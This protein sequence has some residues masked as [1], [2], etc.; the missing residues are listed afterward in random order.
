M[1]YT[2]CNQAVARSYISAKSLVLHGPCH[3][4][5]HDA[6]CGL[7]DQVVEGVDPEHRTDPRKTVK[8]R[9]PAW[10]TE[11][12]RHVDTRSVYDG[13]KDATHTGQR[14]ERAQVKP[15]RNKLPD[16][17]WQVAIVRHAGTLGKCLST[18][19]VSLLHRWPSFVF[20]ENVSRGCRWCYKGVGAGVFGGG[21]SGPG[22]GCRFAH[23]TKNGPIT[24]TT[25]IYK[26]SRCGAALSTAK[27]AEPLGSEKFIFCALT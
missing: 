24:R 2:G 10:P 9:S 26:T 4:G 17:W 7:V 19:R 16:F 8:A 21:R 25:H 11:A 5:V 6:A 27:C 22:A 13:A 18:R 3:I 1:I 12:K 15:Q 20:V 14:G 23:P